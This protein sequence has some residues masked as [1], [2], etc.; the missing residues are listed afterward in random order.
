MNSKSLIIPI[1]EDDK[2]LGTPSAQK[3]LRLFAIWENLT[4]KEILDKTKLSEGQVHKTL[5]NLQKIKLINKREKGFYQIDSGFYSRTIQDA[6]VNRVIYFI[7]DSLD[8]IEK[9]LEI[10]QREEAHTQFL[11]LDKNFEP[12][13]KKNFKFRLNS[14]VHEFLDE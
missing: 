14:L 10:G 3:I 2:I 4:V 6:I 11:Y 5:N 8:E 12:I 9:K 1:E 13:L 7:N